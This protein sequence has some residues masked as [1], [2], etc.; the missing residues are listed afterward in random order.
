MNQRENFFTYTNSKVV[1]IQNIKDG[2]KFIELDLTLDKDG[3]IFA[4]H[5]YKYFYKI[6]NIS[7]TNN[8]LA[9]YLDFG[10][11]KKSDYGRSSGIQT[12]DLT[13]PKGAR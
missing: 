9:D 6:T 5:N 13:H 7:D 2:F 11:R 8:S 12:H 4:T 1:L 10:I 3:D